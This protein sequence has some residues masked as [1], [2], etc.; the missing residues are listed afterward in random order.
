MARLWQLLRPQWPTALLMCGLML[1]GV[2][3]DLAPPKLQQYLVDQHPRSEAEE[4]RRHGAGRFALGASCF[5]WRRR[6]F[7]W[8]W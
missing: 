7:C 1:V 6:G 3:M 4:P 2:A 5:C 8:D